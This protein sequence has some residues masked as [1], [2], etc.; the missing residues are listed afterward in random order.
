[1][2]DSSENVNQGAICQAVN[3]TAETRLYERDRTSSC[4]RARRGRYES[5]CTHSTHSWCI[6]NV[7]EC[8]CSCYS[9]HTRAP[10]FI[11]YHTT[12]G[13]R[14]RKVRISFLVRNRNFLHANSHASAQIQRLNNYLCCCSC[15][16]LCL[17]LMREKKLATVFYFKYSF[18]K[19]SL[20]S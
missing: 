7:C 2:I 5:L 1:M 14:S 15:Y 4:T 10:Y 3:S 17:C 19:S 18:I 6:I 8:I 13:L 9:P 20:T 11:A 16:C 12:T